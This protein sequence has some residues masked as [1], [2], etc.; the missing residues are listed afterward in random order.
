MRDPDD[1]FRALA[2]SPFRSSFRLTPGESA[3]LRAKGLPTVLAHA[4]DFVAKRLAPASPP[5][6]GRQTPF[7]GHPVFVAQHATGTCC[8][9]CLEKWHD[10]PAGRE[11]SEAEQAYVV[12]IVERWLR[13]E[14]DGE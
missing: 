7:R 2:E 10:C 13:G 1:V 8:R 11:L 12:A 5:N 9:S 6:E 4:R 14:G 3:Y